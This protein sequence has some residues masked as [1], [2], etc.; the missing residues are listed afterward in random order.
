MCRLYLNFY[1]PKK[2]IYCY[3]YCA[4]KRPYA[5]VMGSNESKPTT[6]TASVA[7]SE[8]RQSHNLKVESSNLPWSII[9]LSLRESN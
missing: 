7:Q 1:T 3:T 2:E 9:F 4:K 8:E 6:K 5:R